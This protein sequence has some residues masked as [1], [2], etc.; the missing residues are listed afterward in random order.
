MVLSLLEDLGYGTTDLLHS[1]ERAPDA[2]LYLERML[3]PLPMR[4]TRAGSAGGL[5]SALVA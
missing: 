3:P 1:G 4:S 5:L 2:L